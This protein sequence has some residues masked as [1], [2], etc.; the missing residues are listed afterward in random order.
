M[1]SERLYF[2]RR[3]S[4]EP[5]KP[6][7]REEYARGVVVIDGLASHCSEGAAVAEVEPDPAPAEAS[8]ATAHANWAGWM[9]VSVYRCRT[10]GGVASVDPTLPGHW[11]CPS[12]GYS[13][14]LFEEYFQ[15]A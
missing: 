5:W 4:G 2:I 15:L 6:V 11:G 13:T 7:P 12:C 14:F 1:A 3:A 8:A 10:C 9:L